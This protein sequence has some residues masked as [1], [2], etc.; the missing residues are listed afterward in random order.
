M[1]NEEETLP[2]EG[3]SWM[4][5][6][7]K[8][9]TENEFPAVNLTAKRV[10]RKSSRYALNKWLVIQEIVNSDIVMMRNE[11]WWQK[12]PQKYP[13]RRLWK[14]WRNSDD[15][16]K[17]TQTRILL[18]ISNAKCKR[19]HPKV[20]TIP[21]TCKHSSNSRQK[22]SNNRQPIT[23]FSMRARYL[24]PILQSNRIKK[25]L[26]QLIISASEPRQK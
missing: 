9:L 19:A 3:E 18:A 12:Y 24:W 5:L 22:E 2:I 10:I 7:Y 23:L 25:V 26:W 4:T 1:T 15:C 17:S 16:P 20:T 13:R 21:N 14:S 6:V 11:G 8:F